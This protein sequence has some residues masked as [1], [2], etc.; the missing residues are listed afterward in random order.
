M[1]DAFCSDGWCSPLDKSHK[2]PLIFDA[3][4]VTKFGVYYLTPHL[5]KYLKNMYEFL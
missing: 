2:I 4:H 1:L 5:Q 3:N